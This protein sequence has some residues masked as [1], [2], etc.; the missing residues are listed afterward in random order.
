M[1]P[2]KN[3]R[4]DPDKYRTVFFMAGLLFVT[5]IMILFFNWKVPNEKLNEF[6]TDAAPVDQE[7]M[8]RT[9]QQEPPPPE[10]KVKVQTPPEILNIRSDESLL[11]E[12]F[13]FDAEPP[14]YMPIDIDEPGEPIDSSTIIFTYVA[15]MP[16]YP[17]GDQALL[18]A[19][20]SEIVYPTLAAEN[21]IQGTVSVGFV[22]DSHGNVTRVHIIRGADP[23]LDEEAL[24]VVSK[25]GKFKPGNQNGRNVSVQMTVP[26]NFKLQ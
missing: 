9:R 13:T 3:P 5:G 25:L 12:N 18:R 6:L 2:K 20:H 19:I 23:L 7:L 22:V 21:N 14:E 17:G 16:E 15:N 10:E 1:I 11:T 8:I 4:I 26:I 24:R